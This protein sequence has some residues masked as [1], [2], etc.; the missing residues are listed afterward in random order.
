MC[1]RMKNTTYNGG[2]ANMFNAKKIVGV[3][4]VLYHYY[5]EPKE[6]SLE[7]ASAINKIGKADKFWLSKQTYWYKRRDLLKKSIDILS[8]KV[9]KDLI[10]DFAYVRL[11]DFMIWEMLILLQIG[12]NKEGILYEINQIFNEE[13][14][15]KSVMVKEKYG[16]RYIRYSDDELNNLVTK[17]FNTCIEIVTESEKNPEIRP[18]YACLNLFVKMFMIRN[19]KELDT[20][21]LLAN[22]Y[23]QLENNSSVEA[24]YVKNLK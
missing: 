19:D 4:D 6:S 5:I 22:A 18:F 13:E 16:L 10:D 15:I 12:A 11:F 20:N 9:D 7:Q 23:Y 1:V 2:D 24:I 8:K 17:Y 3:K 14:F 21:D